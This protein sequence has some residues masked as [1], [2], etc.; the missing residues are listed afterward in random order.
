MI[1]K[2]S[3]SRRA[4]ANPLQ[5]RDILADYFKAI[6]IVDRD[7][8]HFFCFQ[9][10]CRNRILIAEVVS[11]GILDASLVHAREVYTRAIKNRCS[12]ILVAHNHP[13]GDPDPS[14]EDI[15]V[16]KKLVE[17]GHIIGIKLIDHIIYTPNKLY[18]FQ[19]HGL[20]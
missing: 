14:Y 16:T 17:A 2:I 6:D 11:V 7:K 9:L 20:I 8:E 19:S 18:S 10:S 3:D 15:A 4:V 13:S 1:I 12:Q 5:I